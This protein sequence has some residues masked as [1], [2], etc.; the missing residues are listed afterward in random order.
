MAINFYKIFKD[1]FGRRKDVEQDS[2]S[3][4]DNPEVAIIE[5][6]KWGDKNKLQEL[7]AQGVNPN[8]MDKNGRMPLAWAAR[9]QRNEEA[10]LL[11][12]HGADPNCSAVG[13]TDGTYTVIVQGAESGNLPIVNAL[14]AHKVDLD[15]A[16]QGVRAL[17]RAIN[18]GI[19]K[20]EGQATEYFEIAKAL[21]EAGVNPN[22]IDEFGRLGLAIA[23]EK[24]RIDF[25]ELLLAH[26]ADPKVVDHMG[27]SAYMLAAKHGHLAACEL[28]MAHGADPTQKDKYGLDALDYARSHSEIAEILTQD[29]SNLAKIYTNSPD[30]Q[31]SLDDFFERNN[32]L[33]TFLE[34]AV[35]NVRPQPC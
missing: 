18:H 2:I 31:K 9:Y 25:L 3:Y 28:L 7:L 10:D 4:S 33:I 15:C 34:Q 17:I 22:I 11:L 26:G 13:D 23:A 16:Q 32:C 19:S 21:L 30:P 24:G 5:A 27:M 35:Q 8:V 1:F 12:A 20:P 29:K 6:A 14:I